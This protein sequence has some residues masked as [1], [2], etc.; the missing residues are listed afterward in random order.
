LAGTRGALSPG[1]E[2]RGG[3]VRFTLGAL[4]GVDVNAVSVSCGVAVFD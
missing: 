3:V 1:A 4:A 2:A